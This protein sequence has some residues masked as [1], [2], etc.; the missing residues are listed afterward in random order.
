MEHEEKCRT[1]EVHDKLIWSLCH[2]VAKRTGFDPNELYSFARHQAIKE[3]ADYNP[4]R[5]K[6]TTFLWTSLRNKMF[7]YTKKANRLQ[8]MDELPEM[9]TLASPCTFVE[10]LRASASVDAQEAIDTALQLGN[11]QTY[12]KSLPTRQAVECAL[13]KRGWER[14]RVVS[15][16]AELKI[17]LNQL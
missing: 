1:L 12:R 3:L 4:K 13:I 16:M 10:D 5:A 6:V 8:F 11:M 17:M 2:R 9:L 14:E 15:V 7:T